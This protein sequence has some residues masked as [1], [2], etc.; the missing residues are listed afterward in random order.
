MMPSRLPSRIEIYITR[1]RVFAKRAAST[2]VILEGND[3]PTVQRM[4]SLARNLSQ[5]MAHGLS[6]KWRTAGDDIPKKLGKDKFERWLWR[7]EIA[8]VSQYADLRS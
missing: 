3:S 1:A 4:E 2:R 8:E 7:K 5:H 6:E